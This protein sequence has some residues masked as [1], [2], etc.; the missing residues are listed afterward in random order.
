MP[1]NGS[2]GV[3]IQVM[4]PLP[5]G[6]TSAPINLP[7][8]PG[9]LSFDAAVRFLEQ[10]S[11]GPTSATVTQV[12]QLGLSAYLDQQLA[13]PV[14]SLVTDDNNLHVY[15]NLWNNAVS[16]P[17]QLRQKTMWAWYKM[18]N[19]PGSTKLEW[20]SQVPELLQRDAF[21][22]YTKLLQDMSLNSWFGIFLNFAG[23]NSAGP[24]PNQNFARELQQIFTTGPYVLQRDGTVLTLGDGSAQPQYT[25][26]DVSEV[27]RAMT[28]WLASSNL[29]DDP[30]GLSQMVMPSWQGAHD[31]GPKTVQG[32]V[33][34]GGGDALGDM[35]AITSQ[36]AASPNT[37]TFL[38]K[39]LIKHFVTSNPSPTYISRVSGVWLDDGTGV[40]GNVAAVIKAILLDPEARAGD[41]PEVQPDATEGRVMDS[42]EFQIR[43]MRVLG[44]SV[45][46]VFL[47]RETAPDFNE[48]ALN[49]TSVFGY[50]PSSYTLP[51]TT[52]MAPELA[53]FT[54]STLT[55]K[56]GY[57]QQ[58]IYAL[59]GN[60]V[61]I[62]WSGWSALATGDGSPLIDQ[63]NH[64]CLNGT[65]SAGLRQILLQAFQ[66]APS[67][68][69]G[70]AKR[71]LYLTL[72]S[73]E[74][75]VIR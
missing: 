32:V 22:N 25:Q 27:A 71:L 33:T 4:T 63:I 48:S 64:V 20:T 1:L 24:D 75:A 3:S 37:A 7:I 8:T 40:R 53:L 59:N 50:Y 16:K 26:T 10:A 61:S 41:D 54:T 13:L 39:R 72:M 74:F 73:P 12:Q 29:N 35:I 43:T 2:S 9:G 52:I 5:G 62:D 34:P 18:F 65:M 55:T 14:D 58:I 28:G 42:V 15:E 21:A 57:L 6:G 70:Q 60:N 11:W 47:S 30:E 66:E 45:E 46:A 23:A 67:S 38:S 44:T 56:A 69:D 51:G 19:T 31:T 17:S 36:L 49:S 68:N